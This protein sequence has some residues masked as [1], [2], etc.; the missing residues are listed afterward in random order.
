MYTSFMNH[1]SAS[2]I[3]QVNQAGP[4]PDSSSWLFIETYQNDNIKHLHSANFNKNITLQEQFL[5]QSTNN[6]TSIHKWII[7]AYMDTINHNKT[8]PKLPCSIIRLVYFQNTTRLTA[9]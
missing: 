2:E 8:F 5:N 9:F 1:S 6:S 3:L 7:L 4:L